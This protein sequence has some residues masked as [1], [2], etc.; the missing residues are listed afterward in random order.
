[1]SLIVDSDYKYFHDGQGLNKNAKVSLVIDGAEKILEY[2]KDYESNN[3]S[4]VIK[5]SKN[6]LNSLK[7]GDYTG[8]IQSNEGYAEYKIHVYGAN[9]N[10]KISDNNSEKMRNNTVIKEKLEKGLR[11]VK[12]G[13]TINYISFVLMLVIATIMVIYVS[14]RKK[15]IK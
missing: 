3:G 14:D 15:A 12:T 11:N 7:A 5:F 4:I 13:D 1:M 10:E 2:G 9:S 8:K 6:W